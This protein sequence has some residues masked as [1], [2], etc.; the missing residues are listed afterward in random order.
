MTK[1]AFGAKFAETSVQKCSH[2]RLYYTVLYCVLESGEECEDC[3]IQGPGKAIKTS[4]CFYLTVW[5]PA[6]FVGGWSKIV[7]ACE[8]FRKAGTSEDFPI[9]TC[10][11]KNRLPSAT[12]HIN[13]RVTMA[14]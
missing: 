6:N 11:N 3:W 8:L 4:E 12:K 10:E 2:V 7:F 5:N 9:Q 1:H 13:G 14:K